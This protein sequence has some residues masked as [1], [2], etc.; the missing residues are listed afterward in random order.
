[1]ATHAEV[2]SEVAG[3]VAAAEAQ[4]I[5]SAQMAALL[6]R[7]IASA[8]AI[9]GTTVRG[10]TIGGQQFD[11]DLTVAQKLEAQYRAW[12]REDAAETDAMGGAGFGKLKVGMA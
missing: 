2:T 11:I 4:A 6:R 7:A 5:T 10:I 12:A 3:I 9:S 1:M 8:I